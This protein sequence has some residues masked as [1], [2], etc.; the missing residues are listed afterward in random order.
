[1]P[2][3]TKN[4]IFCLEGEWDPDLTVRNSVEPILTLFE[5]LGIAKNIRRDVAT[6]EELY[7]LPAQVGPEAVGDYKV[8][9][10]AAHGES[11]TLQLGKDSID[12]VEL[13]DLL[14]GQVR[15]TRRLLRQLSH[16][17]AQGRGASG[18]REDD[19]SPGRGR[20]LQVDRLVGQRRL[21]AAAPGSDRRVAAGPTLSSTA[22]CGTTRASL[23]SSG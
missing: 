19:E 23:G 6:S 22:W 15:R 12:V 9:Y 4:G 13:A 1:M 2:K 7:L 16:P 3:K 21:R 5:R 8:L 18:V 14:A 20:L 17:Q 11:G 10:L